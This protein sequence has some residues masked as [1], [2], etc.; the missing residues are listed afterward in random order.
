M[1]HRRAYGITAVDTG[2]FGLFGVSVLAGRD[3]AAP[4]PR[5]RRSSVR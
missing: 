1:G 4:T 5:S 2:Y 3:F